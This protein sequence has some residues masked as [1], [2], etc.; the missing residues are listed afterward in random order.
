[1]ANQAGVHFMTAMCAPNGG[2]PLQRL[3]GRLVLMKKCHRIYLFLDTY[4]DYLTRVNTANLAKYDPI[5]T[6]ADIAPVI[7]GAN[8]S[9]RVQLV[10]SQDAC[11]TRSPRSKIS[12][13]NGVE[14][15]Q[16]C[17]PNACL[18]AHT[19][20]QFRFVTP[21]R[22][23]HLLLEIRRVT[24]IQTIQRGCSPGTQASD[25]QVLAARRRP[26]ISSSMNHVRPSSAD[27]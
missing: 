2:V 24:H 26:C 9:L 13:P 23:P 19:V 17:G 16:P 10:Q 18:I 25:H 14:V 5:L 22:P 8:R 1:M 12:V 4:K 20:S 7:L 27:T 6:L 11:V 3:V 15:I 21:P